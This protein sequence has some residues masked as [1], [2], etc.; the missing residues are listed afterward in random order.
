MPSWLLQVVAYGSLGL[1][2]TTA[3]IV[4]QLR[5]A[6]VRNSTKIESMEKSVNA[7]EERLD[8]RLERIEDKL[9]KLIGKGSP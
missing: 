2:T 9:D 3:A 4:W 5:D 7:S 8:K 1:G 6:S